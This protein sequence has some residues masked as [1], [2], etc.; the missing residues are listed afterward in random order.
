MLV[1]M[2]TDLS[3]DDPRTKLASSSMKTLDKL[4]V[5]ELHEYLLRVDPNLVLLAMKL[6][7][8]RVSGADLVNFSED[9]Y[10]NCSITYGEKKK[11][12][13]LIEQKQAKSTAP[14]SSAPDPTHLQSEITRLKEIIDKQEQEIQAK[15][16]SIQQ[17]EDIVDKQDQQTQLQGAIIKQ[18]QEAIEKQS[19]EMRVLIELAQQHRSLTQSVGK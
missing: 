16:S 1:E 14:P 19:E 17:L 9:D 10:N 12:Q 18:L 7:G 5:D 13:L 11:L 2:L 15:T 4:S 8:E 6:K 3:V